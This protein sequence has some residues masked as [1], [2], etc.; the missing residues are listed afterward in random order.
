MLVL[1]NLISANQK[2]AFLLLKVF[3]HFLKY[4]SEWGIH[5]YSYYQSF[6]VFRKILYK[7]TQTQSIILIHSVFLVK[8]VFHV[9]IFTISIGL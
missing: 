2:W 7:E 1:T 6:P 4:L 3:D 8:F 5:R 9:L